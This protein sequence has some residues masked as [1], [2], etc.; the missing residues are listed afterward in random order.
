M[1]ASQDHHT[2]PF[3]SRSHAPWRCGGA[4][5][6]VVDSFASNGMDL[7][8]A[9][10]PR[11]VATMMDRWR[12]TC[13]HPRTAAQIEQES[14]TGRVP[15]EGH[16]SAI[17]T[18]RFEGLNQRHPSN[19]VVSTLRTLR[20]EQ[21]QGSRPWA[22]LDATA[23]LEEAMR[24]MG[25]NLQ[26]RGASVQFLSPRVGAVYPSARFTETTS[27]RALFALR[28]TACLVLSGAM[29]HDPTTA[30]RFWQDVIEAEDVPISARCE[31]L[32][33]PHVAP[34]WA[35]V[36]PDTL[37]RLLTHPEASVRTLAVTRVGSAGVSIAPTG[38]PRR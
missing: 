18:F 20:E 38:R 17:P 8:L 37:S 15:L 25:A 23:H 14:D 26:Q 19:L 10:T 2:L 33:H 24:P 16:L 28:I 1:T 13:A 27:N 35:H 29:V 30:Q 12:D 9:V 21:R 11:D 22:L 4:R 32:A 36:A 5:W 34:A 6:V 7:F 31:V 3:P